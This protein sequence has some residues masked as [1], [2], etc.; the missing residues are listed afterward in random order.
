MPFIENT[1]NLTFW[2][3]IKLRLGEYWLRQLGRRPNNRYPCVTCGLPYSVD[4]ID[5]RVDARLKERQ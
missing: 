3:T 4:P 2:K 1:I 5:K